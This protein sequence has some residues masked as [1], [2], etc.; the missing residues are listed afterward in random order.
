MPADLPAAAI[1]SGTTA[2]QRV[3]L[4]TLKELPNRVRAEGLQPPTL[5]VIGRVAELARDLAWF[6]PGTP[7]ELEAHG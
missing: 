3:V 6:H 1:Q 4:T 5:M 7:A 2:S